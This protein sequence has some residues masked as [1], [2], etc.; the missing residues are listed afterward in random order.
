MSI[1]LFIIIEITFTIKSTQK[2]QDTD[3]KNFHL[4]FLELFNSE[5]EHP[6]IGQCIF[7]RDDNPPKISADSGFQISCVAV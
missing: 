2:V 6:A 1:F 5:M 7:T 3:Q 4:L